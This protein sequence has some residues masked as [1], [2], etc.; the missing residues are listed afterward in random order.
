MK[1][2]IYHLL[3]IYSPGNFGY[4]IKTS[5]D[6]TLFSNEI[7]KYKYLIFKYKDGS[8]MFEAPLHYG[9]IIGNMK[10]YY[11]NGNL[12]SST[13]YGHNQ[14]ENVIDWTDTPYQI[15]EWSYFNRTGKKVKIE[16][17]LT[18][19]DTDSDENSKRFYRIRKIIYLKGSKDPKITQLDLGEI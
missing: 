18:L 5:Q 8:T 3:P 6:S 17:Y 13:F 12:E 19:Y 14:K 9:L 7:E 15:G 10:T 16:K 4:V 2:C 1:K 11:R